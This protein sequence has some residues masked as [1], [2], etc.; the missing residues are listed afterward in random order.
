MYGFFDNKMP[1]ISLVLMVGTSWQNH[2]SISPEQMQQRLIF[3]RQSLLKVIL[4]IL[5]KNKMHKK[6]IVYTK[7]K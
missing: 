5:D 1:G 4:V 6:M 3:S 7:N 2:Y